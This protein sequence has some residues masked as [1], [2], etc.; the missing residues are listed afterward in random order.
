MTPPTAAPSSFPDFEQLRQTGWA[1]GTVVGRY[2]VAWRGSDEAV[3][4][5][6]AG[7]WHKIGNRSA[8]PNAA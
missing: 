8:I 6:E 7:R 3:F 2:C 1:V 4:L 5:W